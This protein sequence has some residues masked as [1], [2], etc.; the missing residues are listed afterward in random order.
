MALRKILVCGL[1]VLL[2]AAAGNAMA[3]P[4]LEFVEHTEIHA[5]PKANVKA[6]SEESQLRVTLGRNYISTE[7]KDGRVILDFEKRRVF[8][9]K[10]GEKT[11]SE[12]S[13][14]FPFGFA[15]M[16]L[17][18][19]VA[20]SAAL[21][22]AKLDADGMAPALAEHL[23]SLQVPGQNTA[24]ESKRAADAT[25]Y[26]W[27][28]R[29]LLSISDKS[30]PLPSGYLPQY[31][32]WLRYRVGGHP[33]IYTALDS[34]SGV[35][36]LLKVLRVD[37]AEKFVTLRL[38][39]VTNGPDASYSLAGFRRVEPD[40]EPFLTLGKVPR[41][42]RTTLKSSMSAVLAD[43]DAAAAQGRM[44]DA[45]LA[46]LAYTNVTGDGG[47]EWLGSVRDRIAADAETRALLSSLSA[48]TAEQGTKAVATL[49]ALHGRTK[50]PYAY[51]LDVFAANHHAALRHPAEAQNMFLSALS[52][53]P[54]L[55]GAW[56]DLAGLYYTTF[57]TEE[58][59]AC[60]D[61]ARA[62]NPDHPLR[63][64]I[65][66]IERRMVADHPEFF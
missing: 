42:S 28:G 63:R 27:Q 62:M 39:S 33:K 65:D 66:D 14:F 4:E 43:R 12:G 54:R 60:W 15:I 55:T 58:A 16:E 45:T 7:S 22:A 47:A 2:S 10:L 37:T 8:N 30:Q 36:E 35:P 6:G 64:E 56:F 17:K 31:W 11:Y 38:V 44:L 24:I 49:S 32:K 9:L 26:L 3:N 25:E 51:M 13:L 34:R 21:G 48:K 29:Q 61:A 1:S 41:D 59:W 46:H 20:I 5:N 57:R 53:N 50:S 52:A 23:F 40:R 19:R 18:N